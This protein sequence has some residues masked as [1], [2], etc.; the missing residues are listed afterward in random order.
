MET[1]KK[2][3]RKDYIGKSGVYPL[4]GPH[5]VGNAPLKG[6]MEWGQGARGVAG[7]EDHGSSELSFD[8]GTVFGGLDREWPG[9]GELESGAGT[10]EIGVAEWPV[11]CEWFSRS[12][13]DVEISLERHE[14]N[15]NITAECRQRPLV[16]IE[17][18][19]LETGVGAI[20][21]TVANKPHSRGFY[22]S[23]PK[24][25]QLV[26]NGSGWATQLEIDAEAAKFIVHL[27]GEIQCAPVYSGNSWGE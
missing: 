10:R 5:P 16:G 3:H 26:S 6:Q 18:H 8:Y 7:Y 19:L 11:F 22:L 24:K 15:G 14:V 13:H 1:N 4:S 25:M 12:F 23:G 20:T 17:A 9:A 2:E 21:V 27:T